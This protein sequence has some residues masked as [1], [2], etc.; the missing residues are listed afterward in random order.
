MRKKYMPNDVFEVGVSTI[1]KL[2]FA[3]GKSIEEL[4][5]ILWGNYSKSIIDDGVVDDMIS[6][7][8]QAISWLEQNSAPSIDELFHHFQYFCV[9]YDDEGNPKKKKVLNGL[10]FAKSVQDTRRVE[11]FLRKLEV[12]YIGAKSGIMPLA[13]SGWSLGNR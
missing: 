12:Y 10:L 13:P 4:A 6:A 5:S 11:K 9:S 1:A 7:A 8:T 2:H 3:S